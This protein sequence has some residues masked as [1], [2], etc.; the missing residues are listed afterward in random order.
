MSNPLIVASALDAGGKIA[1]KGADYA[2]RNAKPIIIILVAIIA[3]T[4]G[5][6]YYREWR[7]K[8]FIRN[9]AGNPY[10]RA[11]F[12]IANSIKTFTI[13]SI[14]GDLFS[15]NYDTN[16]NS[17]NNALA[18]A[19]DYTE[20]AK[21]YYTLFN[22]NID[23]DLQAALDEDELSDTYDVING[24][25]NTTRFPNGSTLYVK[26]G[27]D[28]VINKAVQENGSWKGTNALYISGTSFFE[29]KETVGTIHFSGI[30]T[31]PND[32][33]NGQ[34]YYIVQDCNWFGS[35]CDFGVVL[36]SQV[37]NKN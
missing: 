9:N 18:L 29:P 24:T 12:V 34:V 31:D 1:V 8:N 11:S 2:S 32:P 28:I 4:L 15:M 17:I 10:V 21:V 13:P 3:I 25:Q 23:T 22:R 30:V 27:N 19:P 16:E 33:N 6:K 36:H 20:L 35:N 26:A 37:T 14:F 7:A 5:P